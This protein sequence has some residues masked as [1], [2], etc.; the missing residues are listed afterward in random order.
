[1]HVISFY[2]SVKYHFTKKSKEV[3]LM[4]SARQISGWFILT[5]VTFGGLLTTLFSIMRPIFVRLALALLF[6]DVDLSGDGLV[7]RHADVPL[8]V[9]VDQK[10]EFQEG[11]VEPWRE[12]D[13][14]QIPV[15]ELYK[16][17]YQFVQTRT[18]SLLDRWKM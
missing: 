12:K 10:L 14:Q 18:L 16:F 8:L 7:V 5:S 4:N 13:R 3:K 15:G 11:H 9:V 17:P 1:M 6:P 2:R